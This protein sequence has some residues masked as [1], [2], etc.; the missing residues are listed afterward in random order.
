MNV[1]R[2]PRTEM[3]VPGTPRIQIK[4]LI[5]LFAQNNIAMKGTTSYR[6][7]FAH[8]DKEIFHMEDI[9]V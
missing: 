8:F 9:E 3:N 7:Y 1:L 4:A 6:S 2:T 5:V